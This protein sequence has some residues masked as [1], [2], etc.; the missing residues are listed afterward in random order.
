MCKSAHPLT[1][2]GVLESLVVCLMETEAKTR[3][4]GGQLLDM[5]LILRHH[6]GGQLDLQFS[7]QILSL[8]L[9]VFPHIGADLDEDDLNRMVKVRS[10][11]ILR[12]CFCCSNNPSPK[13][14]TPALLLTTVRSLKRCVGQISWKHQQGNDQPVEINISTLQWFPQYPMETKRPKDQKKIFQTPRP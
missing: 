9:L 6:L 1:V 4:A 10:P 8:K 11:T 2:G 14:S 5:L 13:S 7:L 3:T 12:I